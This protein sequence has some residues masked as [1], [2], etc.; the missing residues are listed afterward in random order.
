[1]HGGSCQFD[2]SH[3]LAAHL[4]TGHFNPATLTNDALETNPLV[5]TAS[6]FPVLGRTKDGL[7]EEAILL[8][9]KCAV[10]DGLWLL[11]FTV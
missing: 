6:A 4:G 2:V 10:V 11:Y 8:G 7:A 1:M 9:L 3:A 5:L